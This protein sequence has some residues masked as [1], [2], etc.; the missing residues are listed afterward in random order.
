MY[1]ISALVRSRATLV[2]L[3]SA[4]YMAACAE[5][6]SQPVA[7]TRSPNNGM[8]ADD[9]DTCVAMAK[10]QAYNDEAAKMGLDVEPIP[11]EEVQRIVVKLAATP[12]V[13]VQRVSDAIAV[14]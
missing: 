2:A 9:W 10:D 4:T 5:A 12:P 3:L 14:K 7:R 1:L 6:P 11:G 13:V 8:L